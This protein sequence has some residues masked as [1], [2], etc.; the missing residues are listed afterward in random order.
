[1]SNRELF[2][3]EA[4]EFF[5]NGQKFEKLTNGILNKETDQKFIGSVTTYSECQGIQIWMSNE[6]TRKEFRDQS[7]NPLKTLD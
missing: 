7:I 1:M 6:P 2:Y 5:V 3:S 4:K